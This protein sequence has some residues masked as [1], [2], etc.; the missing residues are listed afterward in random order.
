MPIPIDSP[1]HVHSL[2]PFTPFNGRSLASR[3]LDLTEIKVII[4]NIPSTP[5]SKY[6]YTFRHL[7]LYTAILPLS[8][9]ILRIPTAASHGLISLCCLFAWRR[10]LAN[11][12]LI[13]QQTLGNQCLK[14]GIF[15]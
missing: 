9:A 1:C 15:G 5:R 13:W 3:S 6:T 2:N 12:R 4:K 8:K 10:T 11:E 7:L 14:H